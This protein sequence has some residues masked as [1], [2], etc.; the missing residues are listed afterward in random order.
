MST[1]FT[2][3]RKEVLPERAAGTSKPKM[4]PELK[5]GLA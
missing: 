1:A 5:E 2:I 3:R 4:L